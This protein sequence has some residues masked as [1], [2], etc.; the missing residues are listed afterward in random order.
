MLAWLKRDRVDHPL[1]NDKAA[2][3]IVGA[4]SQ[5]DPCKTL[6]EANPWLV[7]INETAGFK[8][9]RRYE[10]LDLIDDATRRSHE[11]LADSYVMLPEDD[12]QGRRQWKAASDFWKLLGDGYLACA[13]QCSA[14]DSIPDGMR[15]QLPILAARGLRALRCQLK[16]SLLRYSALRSEFWGEC[17]R[18]AML[19]EAVDGAARTIDLFSGIQASP[20]DELLQL[21]VFWAAAPSALAP[22]EQDIAE[23]LVAYLTPKLR[24]SASVADA[25]DYFFDLDGSRPPL[26]LVPSAPVGP[27]T[28]FFDVGEARDTLRAIQ[29]IV[30]GSGRL[31]A[32]LTLGAGAEDNVVVRVLRHMRTHWAKELP[33]RAA[34]RQK[35]DERLESVQGFHNVLE[36]IAPGAVEGPGSTSALLNDSWIAE[37][38]SSGGCGVIVPQGKGEGLR[39]GMLVATRTQTATSWSIGIIRRVNELNYR[40]HQLGIQVLSR[41]ALP[42]FLRTQTGARQGRKQE[43][44][45]LL[46][47]Q[48][49]PSGNLYIVMRRDLF[50]GREPVEATLG[51]VPTPLVLQAGGLLES[52]HDFDWLYFKAPGQA[53]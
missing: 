41:D 8:L 37:D 33:P 15:G 14:A 52:G 42:V 45:I 35:T 34:A 24:C 44:G 47:E 17:G 18:F 46:S 16:W 38:V 48:A 40:Q 30:R 49:S 21:M 9:Q 32:G 7:S 4:F 50:S 29:S 36:L 2:R 23:R 22:V 51:D 25:Y 12:P 1:A 27:A 20:N 26:R 43:C 31:P 6:E 28:R 11:R 53:D 39:V 5:R 13:R 3:K 19:A 10:L